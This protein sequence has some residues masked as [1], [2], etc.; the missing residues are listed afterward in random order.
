MEKEG[1]IYKSAGN[2]LMVV[3]AR[4]R[5]VNEA[6]KRAYKTISNLSIEDVQ[7]RTDI[8]ERAVRDGNVLEKWRYLS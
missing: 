2:E 7:Y 3:S 8:G 5:D 6:K 4:G 1:D